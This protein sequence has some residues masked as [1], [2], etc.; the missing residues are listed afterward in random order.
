M[1]NKISIYGATGSIGKQAL[2]IIA[3]KPDEYEVIALTAQ[4]NVQLLAESAIKFNAKVAVIGDNSL[5]C[6]LK[7][8]LAGTTIIPTTNFQDAVNYKA[9]V[10]LLA[11]VGIEALTTFEKLIISKTNIALANK[12]ALISAGNILTDL[13]CLY[14]VKI[15]PVDSEHHAIARCFDEINKDKIEKIILT[16]SGGAL[17]NIQ[18]LSNVTKEQALKHPT[19]N[20]GD[21]I[22]IDCATLVNKG[23]EIIEA[24][25]LF[26]IKEEDIDVII[27]PE[28]IIHSMV[29][30]HDGS[31]IAHLS[32]PD[33]RIAINYGLS[34]PNFTKVATPRLDFSSVA[35]NFK[36]PD[37]IRHH[38]LTLARSALKEN[39]PIIFNS[40]N[41]VAVDFFLA[42]KIKFTDIIKIIEEAMGKITIGKLSSCTD[43]IEANAYIK[44]KVKEFVF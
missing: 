25:Y 12:E 15:I 4:K 32:V 8:L 38:A 23:L 16:A 33:M 30:Y 11:I 2:A 36:Q 26:G 35:L 10:A 6:E 24:H 42:D 21:K 5:L 1:K 18:D 20:M 28:S 17:R 19:W 43:V 14:N 27:H 29:A 3:E 34:W 39:I 40:A 41:E 37:P 44:A 31:V 13:A 9:D 22:T 7:T